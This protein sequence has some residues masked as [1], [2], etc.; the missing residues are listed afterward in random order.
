VGEALSS[1]FHF[2]ETDFR[3]RQSLLFLCGQN[4]VSWNWHKMRFWNPQLSAV[5]LLEEL[6]RQWEDGFRE[7]SHKAPAV[8]L[9]ASRVTQAIAANFELVQ[10]SGVFEEVIV[11]TL[12]GFSFRMNQFW[13]DTIKEGRPTEPPTTSA[14]KAMILSIIM[15]TNVLITKSFPR[16]PQSPLT[17]AHENVIKAMY[18]I[19]SN[20][21]FAALLFGPSGP[22]GYSNFLQHFLGH[23]S[24]C[25]GAKELVL[26]SRERVFSLPDKSQ[27]VFF[28]FAL[29]TFASALTR[30]DLELQVFPEVVKILEGS[31]TPSPQ[32]R[33][34]QQFT[35]ALYNSRNP[36][37]EQFTPY[38]AQWMI[39]AA[40]ESGFDQL[41]L[42]YP[43]LIRGLCGSN[44]AL[45]VYCA[46]ILIEEIAQ[47]T[48]PSSPKSPSAKT[49]PPLRASEEGNPLGASSPVVIGESG[50][51][52]ASIAS[53]IKNSP[54][55]GMMLSAQYLKVLVETIKAANLVLLDFLLP[56]ISKFFLDNSD[57]IPLS[58]PL[59]ALVHEVTLN[60]DYTS[61]ADVLTW[62]LDLLQQLV[63]RGIISEDL[64]YEVRPPKAKGKTKNPP[65][66][67]QVKE[68][69][70]L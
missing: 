18:S 2:A 33:S 26:V 19:L 21:H 9:D 4:M 44:D 56:A 66:P 16:S 15:I 65:S 34:A 28:F 11:K 69:S 23:F 48:D 68:K 37:V 54:I 20:L 5:I 25:S 8:A 3:V 59:Q 55:G 7:S 14:L 6:L 52:P 64:V 12:S 42:N 63:K 39:Q 38:Y 61:R 67:T 35:S 17:P 29:E 40:K 62:Y 31:S 47:L 1:L 30:E 53:L 70:K 49:S 32:L 58:L 13:E 22:T 27:T 60:N 10:E 43:P 41:S 24:T 36:G 46:K 45:A 57:F 50:R 51:L